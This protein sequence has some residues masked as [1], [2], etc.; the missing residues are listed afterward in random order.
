MGL[1]L[2]AIIVVMIICATI[3][4]A[5]AITTLIDGVTGARRRKRRI[6]VLILLA[7]ALLLLHLASKKATELSPKGFNPSYARVFFCI[8]FLSTS[9]LICSINLSNF[10]SE[11]PLIPLLRTFT[12]F[13]L[14]SFSPSTKIYGT[15]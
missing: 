13:A 9:D 7:I 14:S 3:G 4:I 6:V 5:I 8:I 1:H 15:F 2:A 11:V 10:I 12:V